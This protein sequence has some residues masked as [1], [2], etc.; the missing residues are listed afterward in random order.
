MDRGTAFH[1]STAREADD[2]AASLATFT[3]EARKALAAAA[4][5]EEAID[6]AMLLYPLRALRDLAALDPLL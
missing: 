5:A 4:A 2:L 3:E 1:E 6:F